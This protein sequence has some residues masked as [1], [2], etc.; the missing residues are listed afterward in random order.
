MTQSAHRFPH[1]ETLGRPAVAVLPQRSV[2]WV[3]QQT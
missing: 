1:R 2:K 3:S